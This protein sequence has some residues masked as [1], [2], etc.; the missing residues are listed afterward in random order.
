MSR[1]P[2]PLSLE[3]ESYRR[4]RIMDAARILPVLGLVLFLLPA[5]W[6]QPADPN[7][8][9]EAVYLF[10]VWAG[11]I[12]AAALLARPLRRVDAPR[13]PPAGRSAGAEEA[14]NPAANPAERER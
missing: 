14:A 12:L 3:R 10:V 5:L 13:R 8:A 4:R 7:T 1:P 11:L 6:W 9:A 2:S